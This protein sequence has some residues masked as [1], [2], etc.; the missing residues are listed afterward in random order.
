MSAF[1]DSSIVVLDTGRSS[2]KAGLGL[3]ELLHAPAIE[4]LSRVGLRRNASGDLLGS[5]QDVVHIGETSDSIHRNGFINGHA[6]SSTLPPSERPAKVSDYLVANALEEALAAG[7]DVAVF[8]PF[9]KGTISDWIQAEA[10][11]KNVLFKQLGLRRVQNESPVLLTIPPLVS[12][13][14]Y[15]R[16]TQLF[17]ERFNVAGFTLIERPLAQLYAANSLSGVV[18]DIGEYTTDVTPIVETAILHSARLVVALGSW[19]CE[20]Y[21]A[22]ILRSNQHVVKALSPPE[23]PL[24][25][26]ALHA[27]L[28]T[29]AHQIWIDG[30]VK[31]PSDGEQVRPAE[32]EGITDIAAV[33]VAGKER[34]VIETG[35]KKRANAKATAAERERAREIEAMDLIQVDFH[36][37]T[38]TLGKERHRFCEPL[39]DP[40]LLGNP[41]LIRSQNGSEEALPLQEAV[42]YAINSVDIDSRLRLWDGIFVTGDI[43]NHVKGIGAALQS[44]MTMYVVTNPDMMT[45][46]QPRAVKTLKVPEYFANYREKGDGLA[47]FLGSSLVAKNLFGD[48]GSLTFVSKTDYTNVGPSIIVD[49]CPTVL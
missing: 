25:A 6:S 33:L 34:A 37:Q 49:R 23:A 7:E 14:M 12:R 47:S 10:L 11:W 36:G 48:P 40:F 3:H 2:I 28:V 24:S 13:R 29:L 19:H 45:E 44:R 16:V 27:L 18:V 35:M 46:I 38:L 42:N 39:F 41:A 5:N 21:L 22:N 32:D 31:V 1:R 43:T 9:A 8:W 20:Q 26:D 15:Q 17:F 30:L 4:V